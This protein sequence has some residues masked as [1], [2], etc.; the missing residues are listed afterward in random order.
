MCYF[1]QKNL[2]K[3]K[4]CLY[5]INTHSQITCCDLNCEN[6]L[7]QTGRQK[8]RQT[9]THAHTPAELMSLLRKYML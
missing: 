4:R 6:K 5:F 3:N 8:D 2:C 9:H 1:T 7:M